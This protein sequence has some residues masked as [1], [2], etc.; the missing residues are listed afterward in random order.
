MWRQTS[1]TVYTAIQLY[2]SGSLGYFSNAWH[3]IAHRFAVQKMA[4][5]R[6]PLQ[7]S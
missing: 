1:A 6:T 2:Q 5:N 3:I 7:P 4:H